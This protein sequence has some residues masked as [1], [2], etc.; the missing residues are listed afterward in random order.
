MLSQY[1]HFRWFI[2]DFRFRGVTVNVGSIGPISAVQLAAHGV[3]EGAAQK[4]FPAAICD[5]TPCQLAVASAAGMA[6]CLVVTPAEVLM[7]NQQTSGKPLLE[8]AKELMFR[9]GVCGLYRGNA[10]TAFR[11]AAL[12][13]GFFGAT[14]ALKETL[15]DD[16]KYLRRNEVAASA[17]ASIVAGQVAATISQPADVLSSL[18][19]DDSGLGGKAK[20]F[21]NV[22][23]AARTLYRQSGISGFCRGLASRSL[24]CCGAVFI[25]GETQTWLHST[26]DDA[27]L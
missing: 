12:T 20:Q 10:P 16:S 1:N 22:T 8:V 4:L 21:A 23:A 19:K 7:V 24:R 3:L 26:M 2:S 13:C 27:G 6:S 5:K 15:Q 9:A 17:I 11:E 18:M 14:P 25:M